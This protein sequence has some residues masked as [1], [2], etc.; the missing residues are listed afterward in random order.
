MKKKAVAVLDKNVIVSYDDDV[1]RD[2]SSRSQ[3]GVIKLKGQV[4]FSFVEALYLV[5]IE[6][7]SVFDLKKTE[8]TFE[9]LFQKLKRFDS[10]LSLR[11]T[12]FADLRS[13]GY[14][15]K[16]ALKFGS[17]F[18]VYDKGTRPGEAHAK[19]IVYPIHETQK[20]RWNEFSSKNRVAHSTRKHILLAI[21]DDELD[22]S[23]FDVH[24]VRP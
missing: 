21:V 16:T 1:A 6:K 22:V 11:Y 4:H 3:Y 18:R 9:R 2:L 10:S 13:K 7:L 17:D 23:Y 15:V 19:W 20:I 8:Y 14:I 5:S 12:V 24:W